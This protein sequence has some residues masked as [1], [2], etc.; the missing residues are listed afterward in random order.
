MP[1]PAPIVSVR[2]ETESP[3]QTAP[4][5][6]AVST[7]VAFSS[8]GV[9]LVSLEMPA[10][11][12]TGTVTEKDIFYLAYTPVVTPTGG[13]NQPP[14]GLKFGSYAFDLG[15]YLNGQMLSP[16]TFAESLTL[17]FTFSPALLSGPNEARLFVYFWNGTAWSDDGT[18]VINRDPA[19]HQVT[20]AIT[21]LSEFAFFATAPT[22]IVEMPE[23]DGGTSKV[24]LPVIGR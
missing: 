15:A 1:S 13:I 22:N 17:T 23:P 8:L 5:D 16:I 12:F 11:A 21:H 6:P 14:S 24:F 10:G 18:T 7:T 20:I 2:S 19:N 9:S 3:P 4:I